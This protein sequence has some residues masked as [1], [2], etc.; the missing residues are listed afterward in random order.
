MAWVWHQRRRLN[1][2]TSQV[3]TQLAKLIGAPV[4]N[5]VTISDFIKQSLVPPTVGPLSSAEIKAMLGQLQAS[6]QQTL[7]TVTAQ[8]IGIYGIPPAQI[9]QAGYLKPG[10]TESYLKNSANVVSVLNSPAVWTG[11]NNVFNI[12]LFLASQAVQANAAIDVFNAAYSTLAKQG[13]LTGASVNGVGSMLQGSLRFGTEAMSAW[14]K[15]QSPG[16]IV[17]QINQVAKQGSYAVTFARDLP[18]GISGTGPAVGFQK[19]VNRSLLD[20]VV[21]RILGSKK[22]P[23]PNYG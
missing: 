14:S 23:P 3:D 15:G 6:S 18:A 9:E 22:I 7:T 12:K 4:Q 8:A 21:L 20:S 1:S 10:T 17:A 2:M 13:I 5:A 11:K 16:I 19:R